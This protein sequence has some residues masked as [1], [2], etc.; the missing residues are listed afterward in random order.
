MA[1]KEEAVEVPTA[2][3]FFYENRGKPCVVFLPD[4]IG[5]RESQ[6]QMA[7]RVAKQGYNVLL[8]N[9]YYR[10]GRPPFLPPRPD[11]TDEKIRAG[12]FALRTAAARADRISA[13]A[14]FHGGGLYKDNSRA[15]PTTRGMAGPSP[16]ARHT[17][18][19]KRNGR[20]QNCATCLR[21]GLR[22]HCPHSPY[23][24]SQWSRGSFAECTH[25]AAAVPE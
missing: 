16:T 13:A 6:R 25:R 20:L 18:S 9:I 24:R 17:T 23:E 5:L 14:S 4:G 12:Q 8:P 1:V 19:R 10:S 22:Y 21:H 15:T 7:R 3:A 11:F 2:D